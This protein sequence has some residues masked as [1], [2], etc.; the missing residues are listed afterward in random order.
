M[1][2]GI[3]AP[4]TI[5]VLG[6]ALAALL[7]LP[8]AASA[9]VILVGDADLTGMRTDGGGGLTT[10]AG[11][12]DTGFKLS[13]DISFDMSEEVW[14]YSYTFE[15][16]SDMA[17]APDGATVGDPLTPAIS[18]FILEVSPSINPNNFDELIF[19]I[20]SNSGFNIEN[21]EPK[22]FTEDPN[23]DIDGLE[24]CVA[25][26]SPGSN[27][28]NPC[29]PADIYGFKADDLGDLDEALVFSFMTTRA[30]IWGD[31]Y[32]KDGATGG[33]VN[34][35]FNDGIGTDPDSS[36]TDFTPWIAVPDTVDTMDMPEPGTLLLLGSG[37]LGLS[38]AARRR[39][40]T[41]A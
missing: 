1:N 7:A 35:V 30:P 37:L 4:R 26:S 16:P 9:D 13:W 12:E 33:D 18:H 14:S 17:P 23:F 20:N 31:F 38:L 39:R 15:R 25:G 24:D 27:N 8:L 32:G 21:D 19:D 22:T 28:G 29:L 34:I 5:R 6:G 11:W 10:T 36:T 41:R 2:K 3:S 40:G